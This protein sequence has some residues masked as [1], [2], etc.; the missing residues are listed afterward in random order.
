M[1]VLI[2]Y[3]PA[4]RNPTG[5]GEYLRGLVRALSRRA[6]LRAGAN[7]EDRLEIVLFSS[8][9][10]DRLTREDDATAGLEIVDRRIP[11][12]V[13]NFAWHRLEW[14]AVERL[15][16]RVDV[17]HS[18]SPLLVPSRRA[19]RV[20][21]IHDLDF[22]LHPERTRAEIRRDY[23][24][25]A[26]SHVTRADGVI[27]NSE[28]TACQA[29]RLLDVPKERISIC[30][31]GVPEHAR[32]RARAGRAFGAAGGGG[33]GS[34]AAAGGGGAG[35]G[36]AGS[37]GV[38]VGA[39]GG[40]RAGAAGAAGAG[41]GPLLFVGSLEPRKNIGTLL[42]ACA[43]LYRRRPDV[44]DLV[45]AGAARPGSEGWLEQARRPPLAGRVHALGYV[46]GE[47]L[48][49]LYEE[50]SLLLLPSHDEGFGITALEAMATGVPV[51]G[52]ARGALPEVVGDAG[53]LIEGD[54]PGAW[55]DAIESLI[56]DR[57]RYEQAVARGFERA[58]RFSWDV[59]AERVERV[60]REAVSRKRVGD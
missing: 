32:P 26:A 54:E 2:D 51:A 27:A 56:F 11:V 14:P 20:V 46:S 3:R 37:A 9:W 60:Y 19:A 58:A 35:A 30:H 15:A 48:R 45:L 16:G 44:P 4:L 13:L 1:R 17:V 25:L 52:A 28:Y 47:R 41:P 40:G 21:T 7:E 29:A 33:G 36:G 53:V 43:E 38:G 18:P 24:K 39:G 34:A 42:A 49:A 59:T 23:P 8:S 5:V 50:A 6:A 55:A 57:A 10:K 22:L 12:R 31:P